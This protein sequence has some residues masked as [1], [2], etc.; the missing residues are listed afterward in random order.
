ML[1]LSEVWRTYQTGEI[2][3]HALR[4]VDLEVKEGEFLV[5]LG[6]SGSGKSTMLNIMGGLDHPT[7]GTVSVG[8]RVLSD[9]KDTEL[10]RFRR[11]VSGFVFQEFNLLPT[12]NA[13][14]NV[15]I[16]ARL[17]DSPYSVDDALRM[18]GLEGFEARFPHE[19][20]GG[21]QQRVSI[22]RA[23]VKGPKLLF[24]DEITGSLDETT[25]KGVLKTV[26]TLCKTLGTTVVMITHNTS[27]AAIADRVVRLN[28]G[29][30]ES[31]HEN[32]SPVEVDA[33]HF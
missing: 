33:V 10:T 21:E 3:T 4:G 27:I 1:I 26:K 23:I 12:L 11:E 2:K 19:L 5:I 16:G 18:V 14:E 13:Y 6:P 29:R 28:S 15:E 20:S 17:T 25:A 32:E 31:V 30:I 22:A 8:S 7:Q 9:M 24:A